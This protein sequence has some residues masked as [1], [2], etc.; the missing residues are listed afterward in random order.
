MSDDDDVDFEIDSTALKG[1]LSDTG[2][3]VLCI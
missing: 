2:I 1:I 3:K